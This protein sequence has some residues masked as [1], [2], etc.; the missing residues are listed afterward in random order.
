MRERKFRIKGRLIKL[1]LP[2]TIYENLI[3][4]FSATAAFEKSGKINI[5]CEACCVANNYC[6]NCVFTVFTVFGGIFGCGCMKL[7]HHILGTDSSNYRLEFSKNYI[8][9]YNYTALSSYSAIKKEGI[10][11]L[12]K[13]RKCLEGFKKSK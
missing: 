5:K 12:N 11:D 8:E 9:V 6:R 4:R 13:L 1:C 3:E 2:E 7:V 10:K